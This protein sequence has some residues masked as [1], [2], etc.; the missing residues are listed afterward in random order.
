LKVLT[1]AILRFNFPCRK[2][3]LDKRIRK[4]FFCEN[5]TCGFALWYDCR[6]FEAGESNHGYEIVR[7]VAFD[8]QWGFAIGYNPDAV[9][10]YVSW[11]FT[12][13]NG[14]KDYYWD[15]Y[16][17]DFTGAAESYV[18]RVLVYMSENNV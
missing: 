1:K 5:R 15:R 2:K 12:T 3:F 17:N 14:S 7:A 13:E 11:Q 4:G 16:Y 8:S 18:T 9:S 6:F 10:P